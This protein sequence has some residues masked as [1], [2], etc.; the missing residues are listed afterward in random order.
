MIFERNL[1][2]YMTSGSLSV[3]SA[4]LSLPV[5]ATGS[6]VRVPTKSSSLPVSYLEEADPTGRDPFDIRVLDPELA[7]KLGY[8]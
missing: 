6:G 7:R 5:S 8:L 4:P 2:G 3:L 1:G